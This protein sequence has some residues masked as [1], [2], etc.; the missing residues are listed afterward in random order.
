MVGNEYSQTVGLFVSCQNRTPNN[1]DVEH[2][3]DR[4]SKTLNKHP[5]ITSF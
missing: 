3:K 2:V 5:C 1:V 4:G